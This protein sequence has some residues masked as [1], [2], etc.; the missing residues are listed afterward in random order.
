MAICLLLVFLSGDLIPIKVNPGDPVPPIE[1]TSLSNG[2]SVTLPDVFQNG[3]CFFL[4]P[5]CAHC[6]AA[7]PN[8]EAWRKDHELIFVYI[9]ETAEIQSFIQK[10]QAEVGNAFTADVKDL[11]PWGLVTYP[12][13]LVFREGLCKVAMHGRLHMDNLGLL[14]EFHDG[15]VKIRKKQSDPRDR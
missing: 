13:A 2:E 14:E 11:E 8:I 12:A 1:I 3:F 10:H 6:Q 9:G 15:T 4:T 5:S 7:M